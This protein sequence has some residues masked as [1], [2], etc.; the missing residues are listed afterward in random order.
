MI[1]VINLLLNES[2]DNMYRHNI[3]INQKVLV[4]QKPHQRTN[5]LT[6]GLVKKILTSKSRHTRGIKVKLHNNIVGRVQKIVSNNING[7]DDD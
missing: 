5:I 7:D 1:S 2:H 6:S 3:K 4:V